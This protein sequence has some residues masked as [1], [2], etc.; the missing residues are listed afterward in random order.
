MNTP[1]RLRASIIAVALIA[2]IFALLNGLRTLF[3]VV[4]VMGWDTIKDELQSEPQMAG[5][6]RALTSVSSTVMTIFMVVL[7]AATVLETLTGIGLLFRSKFMGRTVGTCFG[8]VAL[9]AYYIS[10]IN[11]PRELGGGF[12]IF[13]IVMLLLFPVLVLVLVN[14]SFRSILVR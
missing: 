12:N 9:I 14:G 4:L 2:F 10:A 8:V 5:L 6:H 11:V 3:I 1:F 7:L 13:S